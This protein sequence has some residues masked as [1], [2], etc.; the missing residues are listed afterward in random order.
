MDAAASRDAFIPTVCRAR[1]P[2]SVTAA[3]LP[4]PVRPSV[5]PCAQVLRDHPDLLG[6]TLRDICHD[7]AD[8]LGAR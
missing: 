4:F 7:G 6:I 8:L 2:P 5:H 3:A 1:P